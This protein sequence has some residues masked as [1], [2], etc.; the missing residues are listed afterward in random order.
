MKCDMP[1]MPARSLRLVADYRH[2]VVLDE[3][4]PETV[5]EHLYGGVDGHLDNIA[6]GRGYRSGKNEQHG[7]Q[8]YRRHPS[9]HFSSCAIETDLPGP[10][11]AAA[12]TMKDNLKRRVRLHFA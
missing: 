2:G 12:G 6:G 7:D 5:V 8:S 3:N 11:P 4:H 10:A 9:L 1:V